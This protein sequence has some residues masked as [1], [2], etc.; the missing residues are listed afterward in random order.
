MKSRVLEYEEWHKIPEYMD[1]VL[2]HLRPKECRMCVVEHEGEIVG[3][4]L[5]YPALLAE[6][7]WIHPEYR[8]RVSVARRLWSIVHR[9][10]SEL[11]YARMVSS[12]TDPAVTPL[13]LHEGIE[14]LPLMVTYPVIHLRDDVQKRETL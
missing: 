7:L 9:C 10:A 2:V 1:H 5:L 13:L 4:W 12:V 6:D 3:R 11:G 14:H 8:K